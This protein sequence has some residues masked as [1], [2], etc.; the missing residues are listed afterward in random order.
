MTINLAIIF[1]IAII[2][3]LL[4]I[5]FSLFSA[6]FYLGKDKGSGER[7]VRALTIRITLSILLFVLLITGN[8]FGLIGSN[9]H[10]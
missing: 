10:L 7:T 8:Y 9:V 2:V 1:K 5:V 4:M 6:L 3:A